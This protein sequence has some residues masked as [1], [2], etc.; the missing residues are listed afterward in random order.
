MYVPYL[1]IYVFLVHGRFASVFGGFA[2]ESF[3]TYPN[4]SI[5]EEYR[6]LSEDTVQGPPKILAVSSETFLLRRTCRWFR[7]THTVRAWQSTMAAPA[8]L[9]ST[10]NSPSWRN[11]RQS[12]EFSFSKSST[13]NP[14]RTDLYGAGWRNLGA[15]VLCERE[16]WEQYTYFVVHDYAK[17]SSSGGDVLKSSVG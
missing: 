5:F 2:S 3:F 1:C 6:L 4:L 12:A 13:S 8:S 16:V 17:K 11:Y 10:G 15:D 14:A 9:S 7:P